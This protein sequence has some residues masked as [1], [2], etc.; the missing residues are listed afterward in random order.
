MKFSTPEWKRTLSRIIYE[1][2]V[3][4]G[5]AFDVMLII[6]IIVNSLLIILESVEGIRLAHGQAL[7]L[8]QYF[9]VA[10]FTLEY[11]LRLIVVE[12]R[13]KYLTSFFGII[14]LLA[15]VPFYVAYVFPFA[16]LFPVLRIL[17]LLRLFSV[18]KMARYVDEAG[19]LVKA[20]RA[21][22]PKI[23]IFLVTILFIIVIV[24]AVMYTV[25][26][27]DNGFVNI[28]ES[29]YWAVVT[30]STVG[31]GD[32]SPQTE[33]GKIIASFLMII[34]YGIIAVPTGIITSEMT[35]IS[36]DAAARASHSNGINSSSASQTA[37][38]TAS[39]P[40][41]SKKTARQCSHCGSLIDL[42]EALYCHR[43][44]NRFPDAP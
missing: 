6:T 18:F 14:D 43:C 36:R 41:K 40:P 7:L 11:I 23:T 1:T 17:R 25:E 22:R 13:R 26:G 27:P 15:I 28:P 38:I 30:V 10:I 32:I 9:F 20:L 35:H 34:G 31:Y 44:G 5:Y 16:R 42:D 4:A 12:N 24:G 3:P 39:S 33:L 19:I 21:S 2:D 37:G 8:L 29:M